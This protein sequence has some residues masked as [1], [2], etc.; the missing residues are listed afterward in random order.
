MVALQS[1]AISLSLN[2]LCL[3]A[4][5]GGPVGGAAVRRYFGGAVS[6]AAR[7]A[8]SRACQ[9]AACL[10]GLPIQVPFLPSP[11]VLGQLILTGA[12]N[13]I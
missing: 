5:V 13:V 2:S 4:A 3:A 7:R 1:G 8:R 6:A 12:A 10:A 9:D 11:A